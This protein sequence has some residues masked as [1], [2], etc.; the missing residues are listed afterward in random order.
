MVLVNKFA[1]L[2]TIEDGTDRSSQNICNQPAN[3]VMLCPRRAKAPVSVI[4]KSSI[5]LRSCC[6]KFLC[7]YKK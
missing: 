3:Y 7:K 1:V 4:F 2:L 6:L 5:H